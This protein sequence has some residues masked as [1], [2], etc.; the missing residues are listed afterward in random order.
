[1]RTTPTRRFPELSNWFHWGSQT[2]LHR[3]EQSRLAAKW[4]N[5]GRESQTQADASDQTRRSAHAHYPR[6]FSFLF[7]F[8]MCSW[9]TRSI[10]PQSTFESNRP[11]SSS[12]R[13]KATCSFPRLPNL[14]RRETNQ[15]GSFLFLVKA[16]A[17]KTRASNAEDIF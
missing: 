2:R 17:K 15:H 16:E 1:M 12:G 5:V 13:N 10:A 4:P 9:P 14:G 6:L 8:R 7:F 11:R 3:Q